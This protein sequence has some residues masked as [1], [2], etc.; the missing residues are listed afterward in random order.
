MSDELYI[1]FHSNIIE[2]TNTEEYN[3]NFHRPKD[4]ILIFLCSYEDSKFSYAAVSQQ[5]RCATH[6]W[7]CGPHGHLHEG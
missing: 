2:F 6:G 1:L 4:L 3:M 5:C 7:S